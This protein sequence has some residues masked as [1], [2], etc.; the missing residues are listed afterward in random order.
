[1]FKSPGCLSAALWQH[2]RGCLHWCRLTVATWWCSQ[3]CLCTLC[4]SGLPRGSVGRPVCVPAT[5]S[6]KASTKAHSCQVP[7][8]LG[9]DGHV[10][11]NTPVT[12]PRHLTASWLSCSRAGVWQH[13]CACS[14]AF[15]AR[16]VTALRGSGVGVPVFT[17]AGYQHCHVGH[18]CSCIH[19][20]L[21]MPA[22]C[23]CC[24]VS[25]VDASTPVGVLSMCQGLY[26]VAQHS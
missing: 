5:A 15:C 2:V 12:S 1:M 10:P 17:P 14:L 24:Q 20:H 21:F 18:T 26:A 25:G 11:L 8:P 19:M 4:V 22:M 13:G 7:A 16:H 23:E 6:V 9:D 3:A